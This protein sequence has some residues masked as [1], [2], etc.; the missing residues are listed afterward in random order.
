MEDARHL[1]HRYDKLRQEVE[2]QV[3]FGVSWV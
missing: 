1:T 2:A 3:S